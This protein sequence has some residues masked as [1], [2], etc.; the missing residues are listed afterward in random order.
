MKTKIPLVISSAISELDPPFIWLGGGKEHIKWF[1]NV[2]QLVDA[3]DA[4]V[5]TIDL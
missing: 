3:L 5:A 2:Q 4:I 1:V